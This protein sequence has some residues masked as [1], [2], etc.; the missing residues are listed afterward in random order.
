MTE[1]QLI[2]EWRW[3]G[4]E[5]KFLY[6]KSTDELVTHWIHIKDSRL[7]ANTYPGQE[8][9]IKFEEGRVKFVESLLEDQGEDS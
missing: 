9:K 7:D 6:E 1:F 2:F 4:D 8:Q 5:E 3:T